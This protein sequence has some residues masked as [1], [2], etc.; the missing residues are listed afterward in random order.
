MEQSAQNQVPVTEQSSGFNS[1]S[2][3]LATATIAP[4][5]Q[6]TEPDVPASDAPDAQPIAGVPDTTTQPN[7]DVPAAK[8]KAFSLAR[9]DA[10][11][12]RLWQKVN[13][14]EHELIEKIEK[15]LD[16]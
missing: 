1:A 10:I 9:I 7:A 13:D 11:I 8:P 2:E 12:L 16:L 4:A 3:G 14:K 5:G 15:M 6:S